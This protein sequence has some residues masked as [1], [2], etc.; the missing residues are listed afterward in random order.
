MI[1]REQESSNAFDDSF[2]IDVESHNSTSVKSHHHMMISNIVVKCAPPNK[3]KR[4]FPG[5]AVVLRPTQQPLAK[6]QAEI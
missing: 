4:G 5:G 2:R 3:S 1:F 6:P